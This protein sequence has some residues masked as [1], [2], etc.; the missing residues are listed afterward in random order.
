MALLIKCEDYVTSY[1]Q[2]K[3]KGKTYSLEELQKFV[4]GYIQILYLADRQLCMV[5]NEEGK[6]HGLPINPVA[7]RLL[8]LL[9]TMCYND[10][11]VGNVLIC[12]SDEIE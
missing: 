7:T 2:V 5:V 6:I 12:G 1:E 9:T 8:K 3:P 11:I 10:F 4:G